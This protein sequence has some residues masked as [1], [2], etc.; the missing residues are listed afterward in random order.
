M[1]N[2]R[3]TDTG[4]WTTRRY[5]ALLGNILIWAIVAIDAWYLWPTQL[6]GSTSMVIVSGHSMEPTYFTGDLVIARKMTPSVGDVI[7]YAPDGFGGSQIV[8]RIV[9]GNAVDGWVMQGDNNPRP[10]PFTPKGSEIRGV[11]LVHYANFGRVTVLL[12][13]PIVWALVLLAA[14]VLLVWWSGDTCEDDPEDKD[15]DN[16]KRADGGDPEPK[17]EEDPDLIDRIVEGTEAAVARMVSSAADAGAAALVILTRPA[18]APRHAARAPRQGAPAYLRVSAIVAV[19]GLASVFGLSPASASSLTIH[20]GGNIFTKTYTACTTTALTATP[21]GTPNGTP[22]TKYLTLTVGIPIGC[23][24][25]PIAVYAYDS[26]GNQLVASAAGAMTGTSGT[27]D[28]TPASRYD[29]SLVAKVYVFIG[30]WG[31]QTT[32][33]YTAPVPGVSCIARDAAGTPTGGP[34]SVAITGGNGWTNNWLIFT[35]HY[36]G[37]DYTVTAPG[38]A[39]FTVTF[40]FSKTPTFPGWTPSSVQ[41]GGAP[42]ALAREAGYNCS[43]L[44]TLV[45]RG[46]MSQASAGHLEFTDQ[47]LFPPYAAGPQRMCPA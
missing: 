15:K 42:G 8:H 4:E 39:Q 28:V 37:F 9:G 41:F 19:V 46:Q 23:Y 26:A 17:A 36:Y 47:W 7:V 11:V 29:A 10:D 45:L 2:Q 25:L 34:C 14:V 44:P 38:A 40:D 35:W 32:W 6:H 43:Q 21:T 20:T 16:D 13:N 12:L 30:T 31:I 1:K 27:V 22:A 18:P 3:G 33:T 24:S 5:L